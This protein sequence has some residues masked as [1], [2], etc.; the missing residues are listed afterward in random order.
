MKIPNGLKVRL[1]LVNLYVYVLINC[2]TPSGANSSSFSIF[3][4]FRTTDETSV[5]TVCRKIGE[6][7]IEVVCL[8]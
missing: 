7:A 8:W 3:L 4:I 6:T 5:S 2:S 1:L